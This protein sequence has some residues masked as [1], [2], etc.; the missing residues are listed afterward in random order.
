[1]DCSSLG[2]GMLAA[3]DGGI[4]R[5]NSLPVSWAVAIS[6]MSISCQSGRDSLVGWFM[7]F[8]RF[9]YHSGWPGI[10]IGAKGTLSNWNVGYIPLRRSSVVADGGGLR[11]PRRVG[12][13]A[14]R[15]MRD[16][17]FAGGPRDTTHRHTHTI[18][19]WGRNGANAADGWGGG[20]HWQ[21]GTTGDRLIFWLLRS[22]GDRPAR[23]PLTRLI[24]L[25]LEYRQ[26][27]FA[28][29]RGPV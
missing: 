17:A 4:K 12:E 8:C 14:V 3:G 2:S 25:L 11:W 29:L 21:S 19:T 22:T 5:L 15:M 26:R 28:P 13:E 18:R 24:P 7:R 9:A 23:R 16:A 6:C 27:R 20:G 1:M 10:S